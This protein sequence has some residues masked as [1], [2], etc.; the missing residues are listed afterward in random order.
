MSYF[1]PR[2]LFAND[3]VFGGKVTFI[4]PDEPEWQYGVLLREKYSYPRVQ[5]SVTHN[6]DWSLI[7]RWGTGTNEYEFLN[8]GN[9]ARDGVPFNTEVGERNQITML[10]LTPGRLYEFYVNGEG[11]RGE[12]PTG[13]PHS[14]AGI[15]DGTGHRPFTNEY[16]QFR[17]LRNYWIW[18]W[19]P[20]M[21]RYS[22]KTISYEGL[23]TQDSWTYTR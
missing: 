18:G 11:Y 19:M 7:K 12:W 6:G 10:T 4:N 3:T 13:K 22:G 2:T 21:N 20:G 8:Y 15:S 14:S 16:E 17:R 1:T 9:F 23:C 5:F